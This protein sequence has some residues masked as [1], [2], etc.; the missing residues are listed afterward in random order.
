MSLRI[1]KAG[2]FDTI[3]DLGRF[4]FQHLGINPGGAMDRFA[5]QSA[6]MLV[7]NSVHEPVIEL[8]FPAST[9]LFECETMF[10]LGG[11]DF[12]ATI[13][14][15]DIPLWQPILAAKNSILQF[16]KWKQGARCYLAI[17]EKLNI[18]KWLHSYSTNVKAG[19]GGFNGRT[20]QRDDAIA[21]KEK[22]DYKWLL[23]EDD[24]RILNWKAD[25]LWNITPTDR[26]AVTP[27]NE[28]DWL[29]DR[30]KNKFLKEAFVIGSLADRMGYRLQ[31]E[32]IP[33]QNGE[34]IS[35]VVSFGTIQLLPNGELI[36]LMADHQTAG[37]YPRIA[38]VVSAHL[39]LLAQKQP[40]DEIYFRLTDQQRAEDLFVQQHQHLLQLQN[41]CKFKLEEFFHEKQKVENF[42][43]K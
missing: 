40:G 3:Q 43:N 37:G 17:R 33:K 6:N 7:G 2:V 31:G 21:F 35:S 26:I 16:Q 30:A 14:G 27:G 4:G 20:L 25:I 9:L 12:S 10:A 18:E 23:K 13:N 34:L 5:A 22:H 19:A 1:I 38:H 39:P 42:Q 24:L 29:T 32:L 28:W 15:D 36:I 11:A 41:A 8:H